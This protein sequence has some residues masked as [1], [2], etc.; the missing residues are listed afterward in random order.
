LQ[1]KTCSSAMNETTSKSH[2]PWCRTRCRLRPRELAA[3]L[4]VE[5]TAELAAEMY[6]TADRVDKCF[7]RQEPSG[8]SRDRDY[9]MTKPWETTSLAVPT[10][11]RKS[12]GSTF[13]LVVDALGLRTT[14]C[15]APSRRSE[16]KRPNRLRST[17]RPRSGRRRPGPRR[18]GGTRRAR[19]PSAACR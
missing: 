12:N 10:P 16:I 5:L 19:G 2:Q 8:P 14:L 4:T 7:H 3:H 17:P 6:R 15:S 18:R 1:A 9:P 13:Q 11:M